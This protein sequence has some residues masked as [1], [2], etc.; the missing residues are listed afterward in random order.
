[1]KHLTFAL[2]EFV[3][4]LIKSPWIWKEWSHLVEVVW[5]HNDILWVP[6]DIDHLWQLHILT[7][8]KAYL[9]A[10][11]TQRQWVHD[12]QIISQEFRHWSA[13]MRKETLILCFLLC[14][15]WFI[16]KGCWWYACKK[17]RRTHGY[18]TKSSCTH[19]GFGSAEGGR[20]ELVREMRD[21]C[22]WRGQ[23]IHN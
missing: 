16:I 2:Q 20:H 4:E 5:R 8:T 15:W 3:H 19:L 22:P 1:M 17:D 13:K 23:L 18:F 10:T 6:H 11:K 7:K 12:P 14:I 21:H 9:I